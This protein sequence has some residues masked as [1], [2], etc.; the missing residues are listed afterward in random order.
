[1]MSRPKVFR[2]KFWMFSASIERTFALS[3]HT[4]SYPTCTWG[5]LHTASARFFCAKM[6]PFFP[7]P[8]FAGF[9]YQSSISPNFCWSRL[10][11]QSVV[12]MRP[13]RTSLGRNVKNKIF[14]HVR[15]KTYRGGVRGMKGALSSVRGYTAGEINFGNSIRM[16]FGLR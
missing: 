14:S 12:S 2:S 6:L 3:F 13:W 9:P 15:K 1:M 5:L 11:A 16:E 7:S 8:N 4:T 10:S